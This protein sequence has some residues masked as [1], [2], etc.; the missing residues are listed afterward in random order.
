M[1]R[2]LFALLTL[3]TLL[4]LASCATDR[5]AA[6]DISAIHS[7]GLAAPP[8]TATTTAPSSAAKT[9]RGTIAKK[10]G[11]PAGICTR[12]DCSEVGMTFTVDSIKVDAKCTA[13]YASRPEHGHFIVVAMTIKTTAAF[14]DDMALGSMINPLSFSVVGPDGI[15]EASGS[16]GYGCLRDSE[17]L[18]P[19]P[20][21][22]SSQYVGKVV[23]DSRSTTGALIL[24]LSAL[25]TGG[26]EWP[27]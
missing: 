8:T 11:E 9:A 13:P 15:T 20:W 16:G 12:S 21:A 24:R 5:P 4:V 25:G 18:P 26:W 23:V 6:P 2:T 14:D 10:V 7:S 1:I 27:F 17:Q 22:P 19:G 3:T